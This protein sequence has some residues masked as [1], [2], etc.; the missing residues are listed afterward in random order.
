VE[1]A[2]IEALRLRYRL[3]PYLYTVALRSAET[4]EPIMRAMMVDSPAD[5]LAWRAEHQYMLGPDLLVAPMVSSTQQRDVYLPEGEWVDWWTGEVHSG[6]SMLR[7]ATPLDQLPL[8][9]RRGALI[10]T[11]EPS[12]RIADGPWEGLTLVSF[13][14]G[15][16]EC[17]IRD[18]N[19]ISQVRTNADLTFEVTGPARVDRVVTFS[20]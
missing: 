13:A 17:E 1:V 18:D 12:D 9:V 14:D 2:V 20:L 3:L 15:P 7:V 8:F 6:R 10:P 4:G 11:I 5:P 16:A 19:G